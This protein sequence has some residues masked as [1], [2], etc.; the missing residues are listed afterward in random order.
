MFLHRVN[1]N[2]NAALHLCMCTGLCTGLTFSTQLDIFRPK[3]CGGEGKWSV[4]VRKMCV[5]PV[6]HPIYLPNTLCESPDIWTGQSRSPILL[7]GANNE[8]EY[9]GKRIQI[10]HGP[11][12]AWLSKP[13]LPKRL[14]W[15]CPVRSALK[16]TTVLDLN[17]F[18][19][20]L[21]IDTYLRIINW[22]IV[23]LS[24]ICI[25]FFQNV[26]CSII[27]NQKIGDLFCS[28]IFLDIR[29]VCWHRALDKKV[30]L[31]DTLNSN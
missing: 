8:V 13:F 17:S 26:Y 2:I 14:G 15:P 22:L 5:S 21:N 16:R 3:K 12:R 6:S 10:L 18:S 19:I 20:N 1:N 4:G 23:F 24:I 11:N 31:K 30:A 27:L 28:V 9:Y 25:F 7:C 29:T